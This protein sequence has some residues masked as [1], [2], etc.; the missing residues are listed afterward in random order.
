MQD[1]MKGVRTDLKDI[2]DK[3]GDFMQ[4][5][6]QYLTDHEKRISALEEKTGSDK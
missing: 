1:S 6:S 4:F 3:T 2:K 5:S